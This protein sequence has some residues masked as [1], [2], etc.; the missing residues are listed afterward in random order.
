MSNLAQPETQWSSLEVAEF[1]SAVAQQDFCSNHPEIVA[2]ARLGQI[3]CLALS[4]MVSSLL[5]LCVGGLVGYG[6]ML[7]N[8]ICAHRARVVKCLVIM[9]Q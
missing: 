6:S 8:E 4:L 5:K 7:F 2:P 3:F 1:C 9:N